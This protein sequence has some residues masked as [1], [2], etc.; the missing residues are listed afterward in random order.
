MIAGDRLQQRVP[1][2]LQLDKGS[3][4][5]QRPS[6]HIGAEIGSARLQRPE[7][8][9]MPPH[10]VGRVEIAEH[11]DRIDE[12]ERPIA[13]RQVGDRAVRHQ[14]LRHPLLRQLA[15]LAAWLDT[16]HL[17]AGFK[18]PRHIGADAGADIEAMR[19][20]RQPLDNLPP[21]LVDQRA[22]VT[23]GRIVDVVARILGREITGRF[24]MNV[25]GTLAS[26]IHVT[27]LT[28][29]KRRGAPG[30]RPCA[31]QSRAWTGSTSH[32]PHAASRTHQARG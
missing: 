23:E 15:H 11:L 7:D 4:E 20:G 8:L 17:Q 3:V 28:G 6:V 26:P 24:V 30:Q 10:I 2:L 22:A 5:I 27:H 29:F 14:P 16:A 31:R 18:Q 9:A 21:Q 1:R 19:P 32:A 12:V 13:G 25:D